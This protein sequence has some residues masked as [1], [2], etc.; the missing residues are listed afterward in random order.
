MKRIKNFALVAI[1]TMAILTLSACSL[2]R[3]T[4]NKASAT[5]FVG[6]TYQ[7]EASTKN[8]DKAPN[9]VFA[10]SDS[11]VATVDQNGLVT[12]KAAGTAE[13][14]VTCG[15]MLQIV[16]ITVRDVPYLEIS[17]PELSE[18]NKTNNNLKNLKL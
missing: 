17:G 2:K 12:A 3:L 16:V 15:K 4:V 14:H 10:T 18:T 13:I 7:V 5:V 1:I 9:I 8:W 11:I 6:E